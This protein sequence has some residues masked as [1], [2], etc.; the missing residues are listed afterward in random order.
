VLDNLVSHYS[1]ELPGVEPNSQ[2]ASEVAYM[3]VALESPQHQAPNQQMAS[4]TH[5]DISN[6]EHV[7]S[8]HIGS[9]Q[10]VPDQVE[11][12]AFPKTISEPDY[13]I[14]SDASDAEDE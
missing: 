11:T 13:M 9:E 5:L 4:T 12:I 1:G 2:I 3:E 7:V 6:P 10:T 14:T 8:E